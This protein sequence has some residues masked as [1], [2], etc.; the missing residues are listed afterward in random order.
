MA[1]VVLYEMYVSTGLYRCAQPKWFTFASLL[2]LFPCLLTP[3]DERLQALPVGFES[4][5]LPSPLQLMSHHLI[6]ELLYPPLIRFMGLCLRH[7]G[8]EPVVELRE[9]FEGA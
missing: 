4:K 6:F 2:Y 9:C 7:E 8:G 1:S 3:I 5:H